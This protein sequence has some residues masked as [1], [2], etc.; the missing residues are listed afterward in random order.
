M[1][2]TFPTFPDLLTGKNRQSSIPIRAEILKVLNIGGR[3]HTQ[4]TCLLCHPFHGRSLLSR[5]PA[6]PWILSSYI[7]SKMNK[8][9]MPNKE[10]YCFCSPSWF[11]WHRSFSGT[12]GKKLTQVLW[13]LWRLIT[14]FR[15][16]MFLKPKFVRK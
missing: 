8:M 3:N 6:V 1:N 10:K 2:N 16:G 14:E 11:R 12:G 13:R 4:N 15:G 5:V 9:P 7:Q